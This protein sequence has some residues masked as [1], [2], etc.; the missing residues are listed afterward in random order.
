MVCSGIQFYLKIN[1]L[2]HIFATSKIKKKI[3]KFVN[4]DT[5][6]KG[7]LNSILHCVYSILYNYTLFVENRDENEDGYVYIREV[8]NH[9]HK[10]TIIL[11]FGFQSYN[12]RS[13]ALYFDNIHAHIKL[14]SSSV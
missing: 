9:T 1:I 5:K 10:C 6:P 2:Q 7:I 13:F 4:P 8:L 14:V 12:V 11:R 3:L